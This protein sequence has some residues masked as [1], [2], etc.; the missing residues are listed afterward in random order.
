[1]KSVSRIKTIKC[2]AFSAGDPWVQIPE[3]PPHIVP[4]LHA[5]SLYIPVG[6]V[7]LC[8][9][10]GQVFPRVESCYNGAGIAEEL[11]S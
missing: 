1:M 4:Y 10:S 11:T 9:R 6:F 2:Y 5:V 3:G 7:I 8:S